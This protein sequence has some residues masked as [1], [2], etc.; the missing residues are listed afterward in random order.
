MSCLLQG[1]A[2]TLV[3]NFDPSR[4]WRLAVGMCDI[5]RLTARVRF[6]GTKKPFYLYSSHSPPS[7][8]KNVSMACVT[9]MLTV[10]VISVQHGAVVRATTT[11]GHVRATRHRLGE[12]TDAIGAL[13]L[14]QCRS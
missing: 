13:K 2:E 9:Y 7:P 4:W 14:P 6:P 5:E 11:L 8:P 3:L 10:D 12:Q 1:I